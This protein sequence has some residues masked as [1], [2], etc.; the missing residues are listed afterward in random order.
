MGGKFPKSNNNT[1]V[2]LHTLPYNP[3]LSTNN[4]CRLPSLEKLKQF[5]NSATKT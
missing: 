5:P 1:L 4:R 3:W 2:G